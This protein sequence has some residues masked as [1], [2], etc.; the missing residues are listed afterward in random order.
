M[1]NMGKDNKHNKSSRNNKNNNVKRIDKKEKN[2]KKGGNVDA[3]DFYSYLH[4]TSSVFDNSKI[5][6]GFMLLLLNI[7][8][9]YV[10]F[11]LSPSVES[12]FKNSFGMELLMFI[13]LWVG[14]KNL[15]VSIVIT[16]VFIIIFNFLLNE[17]SRF[18]ILPESFTQYYNGLDDNKNVPITEE[19]IIRAKK[20][21]QRSQEQQ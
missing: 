13:I 19:D 5:F 14:T 4:N 15:L 21:L 11:K 16:G 1:G 3:D 8:T 6:A 9:K 7:S 12:F 20:T 10:K 18:S 17:E 2:E